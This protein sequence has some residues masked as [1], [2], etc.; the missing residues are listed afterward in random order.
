VR[1]TLPAAGQRPKSKKEPEMSLET[2]LA[3][4]AEGDFR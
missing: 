1:A 4:R 3:K 2:Y